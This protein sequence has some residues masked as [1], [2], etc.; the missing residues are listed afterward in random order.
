M[1][2]RDPREVTL[3]RLLRDA[4]AEKAPELDWER[5]EG[6]LM[7]EAKLRQPQASRSFQPFGWGALAVAA[8]LAMW[9]VGT[10]TDVTVT[11]R[12]PAVV[13]ATDLLHRSGDSMAVG[14]RVAAGEREVSVSH[15]GRATWTL[16]PHGSAVLTGKGE[17]LTVHLEHGS[18]LSEVVPSPQPETYVV[19]AASAR[20]AVRGTVFQVALEK[21]RVI[22][23]VREG[24]VA[25]GPVGGAPA[26]FLTAPAHGDF[27]ADG[28]SGSLDGRPLGPTATRRAGPNRP[29]PPR[30]ALV[31]PA[32]SA[33]APAASVELPAE[34]SISDI[35]VGIARIVD[36]A[37]ECFSQHTTAAEGVRVTVRTALSL[38]IDASG[39]ASDVEFEPPL[40]PEAAQCA[41]A[42]ISQVS[43]APSQQGTSVTRMLELKR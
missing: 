38:K 15:A 25:V 20:I 23:Q 12:A 33:V 28:R 9:L 19:E 39:V 35:E 24:T 22:V 6:R 32:S 29:T 16:S 34:P 2:S 3:R 31:P 40:S 8:G 4:R 30:V 1:S 7:R 27:A 26:F 41:A 18:V 11:E 37:T 43:F 5:I 17:R 36:S 14:T 21:G 10:P 13:E 42:R